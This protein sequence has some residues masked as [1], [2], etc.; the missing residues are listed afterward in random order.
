MN[1]IVEGTQLTV[2]WHVG[3]LKVSHVQSSVV[4]QFIAD[5]EGEFGKETPLNK[6]RGKVHDYLGMT[7]D[8]SKSGE[9]TVT[10]ID[11][12]KGILH[13]APKEMRGLAATPAASHL[14]QTNE[15]N[16]IPL[17][18]DKAETYVYIVMQLLYLSQRAR[19]DI[20]TAVSFLCGR[21]TKPDEDDYKKLARVLKYLDNTVDMPLVL[22]ADATGKIRWWVDASYAVHADM[23][24]HTTVAPCPW[25]RDQSIAPQPNKNWLLGALPRRKLL[26]FMTSCHN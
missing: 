26:V 19:P 13:D 9:V 22:A 2:A 17:E 10:M 14:F 6:S 12:I 24:S 1:K 16:P 21:L 23:K 20:H 7:L 15:V 3:D 25:E 8:F 11:Y 5:M 4:D 18:K